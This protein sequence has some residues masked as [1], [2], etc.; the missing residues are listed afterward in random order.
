LT[1]STFLDDNFSEVECYFMKAVTYRAKIERKY[2]H[3]PRYVVIPARI[4]EAWNLTGTTV[5]GTLNGIDLG[6]RGLKEWGDGKR[7]FFE[8]PE[9]V[10]RKAGVDTG[11]AVVLVFAPAK[12]TIPHEVTQMLA[13]SREYAAVWSA[14]TPGRRRQFA[15]WV[16]SGKAEET[17]TRR[18]RSLFDSGPGI[19]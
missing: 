5:T 17:R 3:L 7:W 11:D 1:P 12:D 9:P 6:R 13:V 14:L 19:R 15:E 8:V 18:A 16:A 10:Y 4:S 2:S